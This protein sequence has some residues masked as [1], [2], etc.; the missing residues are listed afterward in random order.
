MKKNQNSCKEAYQK[1]VVKS[2][3][4]A[5]ELSM[6]CPSTSVK[7]CGVPFTPKKG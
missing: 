6:N 1:P 3:K 7:H 4:E 5:N 2:E